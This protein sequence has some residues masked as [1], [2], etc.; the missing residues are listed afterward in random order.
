MRQSVR[1]CVKLPSPTE[2]A[3]VHLLR[4]GESVRYIARD[5]GIDRYAV[6]A[7]RERYGIPL[8]LTPTRRPVVTPSRTQVRDL[9][10]RSADFTTRY[11]T[12]CA[13]R[14]TA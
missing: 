2:R 11:E 3:C 14:R 1:H 10:P 13:A 8:N 6:R 7:I 4:A 5:L 9:Q 12:R